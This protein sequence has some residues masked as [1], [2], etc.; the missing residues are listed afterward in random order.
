MLLQ[1]EFL[2]MCG[3][4]DIGCCVLCNTRN[5]TQGITYAKQLSTMG[6]WLQQ[7]CFGFFCLCFATY[8]LHVTP[9][10][11]SIQSQPHAH[12]S[13]Q[14]YNFNSFQ[15]IISSSLSLGTGEGIPVLECLLLRNWRWKI[16]CPYASQLA[17]RGIQGCQGSC[18]I[19]VLFSS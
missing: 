19:S 10:L 14:L 8:L 18:L 15:L 5:G 11:M 12:S 4:L 2:V 6:S 16:N 13:I 1:V 9:C 3:L 17:V 7:N